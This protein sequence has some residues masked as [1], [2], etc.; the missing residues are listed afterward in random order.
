ME[1]KS[2]KRYQVIGRR[3]ITFLAGSCALFLYIGVLRY[4]QKNLDDFSEALL[5]SVILILY[6]VNY[7]KIVIMMA[8][9]KSFL[10]MVELYKSCY[11]MG[12]K[13]LDKEIFEKV[14]SK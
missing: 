4:L 6:T 3:C 9:R 8:Q 7:S 11:R 5:M 14:F 2:W 12:E 10:R 1:P 13:I